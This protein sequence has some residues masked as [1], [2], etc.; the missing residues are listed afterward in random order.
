VLVQQQ[1]ERVAAE[2]LVRRGVL[3]E[4]EG[5]HP[6][7]PAGSAAGRMPRCAPL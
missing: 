1:G 2:Q 4:G 6:G 7:D 3:G 5:G